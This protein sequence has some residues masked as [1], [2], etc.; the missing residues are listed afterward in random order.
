MKKL[1]LSASAF[2]AV[3]AN[4]QVSD[5][6][7]VINQT[8]FVSSQS[9]YS[10][11]N[12]EVLNVENDDWDLAFASSGYGAS[13][14]INGAQ[15]NALYLTPYAVADWATVD[16]AG[17]S[18]WDQLYDSQA[19]W[20]EGAF[21]AD[22]D[23]ADDFDMGWGDYS[24]TTHYVTGDKIF[25]YKF[26]DGNVKKVLI[27]Q[28]ASGVYTFKYANID[29]T[30]EV[31]D[32]ITKSS[33]S[34]KNFV[35]YSLTNE[36]IVDREPAADSW[37]I[38]FTKY[39]T[40]YFGDGTFYY[41]V[42]GALLNGTVYAYKDASVANDDAVFNSQTA[43]DSQINTLGWGWKTYG[44]GGYTIDDSS[45]FFIQDVNQNVWKFVFTGYAGG[46]EGK[47]VFTKEQVSLASVESEAA[48]M[49]VSIYPN[50]ASSEVF[51]NGEISGT[52]ANVSVYSMSG[53]L[54]TEQTV[55]AN[56]MAQSIDVSNLNTGMYILLIKS[57][58]G[59]ISKHKLSIK[60]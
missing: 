57:N 56:G 32:N 26:A 43:F 22:Y 17:Y 10:L 13:I 16:T 53:Q 30:N 15:G 59:Q 51:I 21:N 1:L 55:D 44:G 31:T 11:E 28:L 8:T 35:Y 24:M 37:D 25:L 41:G 7:Y 50:P 19:T 45:A 20:D 42:T 52:S 29:N 38:V 39:Q 46:T 12:G 5:S 23:A 36:A 18:A 9:Y 60:H 58:D 2:I 27:E 54:V 47:I 48:L 14:R 4:A 34:T 49:D 3:F 6:V 40:D 33:Y